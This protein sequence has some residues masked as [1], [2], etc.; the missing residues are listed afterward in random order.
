MTQRQLVAA[1]WCHER[2]R[3]WSTYHEHAAQ[4]IW[5]QSL[6]VLKPEIGLLACLRGAGGGSQQATFRQTLEGNLANAVTEWSPQRSGS[7][8]DQ[9]WS[10]TQLVQNTFDTAVEP[11]FA[12]HFQA[13]WVAALTDKTACAV[14][15]HGLQ[16]A[17]VHREATL[18]QLSVDQ[19]LGEA[20]GPLSDFER[21]SFGGK[22][23]ANEP[24]G[25]GARWNWR[26]DDVLLLLSA[27]P[28][29]LP[30][31]QLVTLVGEALASDD[32][33]SAARHLFG[34][35]EAVTSAHPAAIRT[36]WLRLGAVVF[37]RWSP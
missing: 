28:K 18:H 6:V 19:T 4:P 12:N 21:S 1:G 37:A 10:L 31:N 5:P 30:E 11:P 34:A 27:C 33:E 9:L 3:R 23:F 20:A 16:R 17:F 8:E 36:R 2:D 15:S 26:A 7:L 25:L 32:L 29:E 22:L 35:I 14:R 13:M 24:L